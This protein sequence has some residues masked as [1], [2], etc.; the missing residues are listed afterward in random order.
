[1]KLFRHLALFGLLLGGAYSYAAVVPHLNAEAE[2]IL[3]ILESGNYTLDELEK[4]CRRLQEI[5]DKVRSEVRVKITASEPACLAA[6]VAKK[7]SIIFYK[8]KPTLLKLEQ[9][10]ENIKKEIAQKLQET[11]VQPMEAKVTPGLEKRTVGRH[12][13]R[14]VPLILSPKIESDIMEKRKEEINRILSLGKKE[15]SEEEVKELKT[16]KEILGLSPNY[17]KEEVD[18]A[19]R[20]KAL[21]VHPDKNNHSLESTAAFKLLSNAHDLVKQELEEKAKQK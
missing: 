4:Y 19:F 12:E 17:T 13:A 5:K 9:K 20:A 1:M 8:Q 16:E 11:E 7:Q 3:K 6:S 21:L 18:K 15:F 2:N 10:F 14:V